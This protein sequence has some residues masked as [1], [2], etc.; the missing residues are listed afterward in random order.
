MTTTDSM[1]TETILVR[2]VSGAPLKVPHHV[3]LIMD[4]NGRWAR[5]RN[6]PRSAGHKQGAE[7]LRNILLACPR[8][9]IKHL[10]VYAFSSENWQRPQTE[11]NDLFGLLKFYLKRELALIQEN[12][13][14]LRVIGET[15]LI[16]KDLHKIISDA[17]QA[18]ASNQGFDFT[19]CFSYGARQELANAAR[20]MANDVFSGKLT[21]Q[22]ITSDIFETY[23]YTYPLPAPDLLIRTGGEKRLSNFLLWQSAYTELYFTDTL[24]PDF[25]ET[26]FLNACHEFS[27]RERRYGVTE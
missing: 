17:E 11:I 15:N 26:S 1:P 8:I 14:R 20:C 12:G 6:L 4:G 9:G 24:W 25:T 23:L 21:P 22:E 10:T 19:V 18:T 2:P 7:A 13:I 27:Y 5:E 3:A 16:P